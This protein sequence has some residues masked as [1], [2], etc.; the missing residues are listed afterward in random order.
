MNMTKPILF[1]LTTILFS[2]SGALAQNSVN[3][4]IEHYLQETPFAFGQSALTH[5]GQT[6]NV[7]RLQYYISEISVEDHQGNVTGF[8]SLWVLV[9]ASATTDIDLGTMNVDSI[10]AVSFH[11]GVD[12]AHNHLDPSGWPASHPLAHKNPSMHWGWLSGYRFNAMEGASG[13]G[14]NQS[15]ELHGL[16]N[17][18]YFEI[19]LETNSKAENGVIDIE[20]YAN[21]A[22]ILR[23]LSISSGLISHGPIY[24]AQTSLENMRDY[25]FSA[26]VPIST[27]DTSGSND[28]SGVGISTHAKNRMTLFPNPV[29]DV[30]TINGL[31]DGAAY[32]T[33]LI[34]MQGAVVWNG[35][36]AAGKRTIDLSEL[37]AGVY[38]LSVTHAT[39]SEQR[40][41]RLVKR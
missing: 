5:D 10:R 20:V 23:D 2:F 33:M 21:C 14:L 24:E 36:L 7:S 29:Q 12:S 15:Y 19:T 41:E 39:T 22:E 30:L 35:R 40:L 3:L 8:D 13:E 37:P 28:T 16:G 27:V 32:E 17:E 11:V 31:R 4:S 26:E 25:V 6:F 9:D 38:Q 34:N 18:N 1:L